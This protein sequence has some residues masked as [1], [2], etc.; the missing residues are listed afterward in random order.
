M[1][2]LS[3]A[4]LVLGMVRDVAIIMVAVAYMLWG[5]NSHE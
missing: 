5:P 4:T 2:V 1:T 3:T